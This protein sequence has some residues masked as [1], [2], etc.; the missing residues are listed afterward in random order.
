MKKKLYNVR[1]ETANNACVGTEHLSAPNTAGQYQAVIRGHSNYTNYC[2]VLISLLSGSYKCTICL[3]S[4]KLYVFKVI[5]FSMYLQV[6]LSLG[7]LDEI[8]TCLF[9]TYTA[10]GTRFAMLCSRWNNYMKLYRF[11]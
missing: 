2:P 8:L 5:H 4:H 7:R 3:F 10:Y 11:T 6:I 1:Q 9:H